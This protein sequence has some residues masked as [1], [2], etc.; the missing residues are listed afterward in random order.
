MDERAFETIKEYLG[1][2]P[3][4]ES[5]IA[6]GANEEGFWWIKLTINLEHEFAWHTVQELGHVINYIS[7]SERLPA[8]FYPVSPP[9]YMNGGPYEFLSWVIEN[10]DPDFRPGTLK[11]VLEGRLPSP[12]DNIEE[13]KI[14]D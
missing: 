10:T 3:A 6:T 2:I 11:K 13:W 1:K 7:I 5:P 9:P 14:I 12:V 8:R 4:I